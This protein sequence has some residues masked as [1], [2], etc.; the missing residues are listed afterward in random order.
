MVLIC[1]NA[2]P[3][4][5]IGNCRGQFSL[6]TFRLT[7]K[8][9]EINGVDFNSLD[10]FYSCLEKYLIEGDCP[11]GHNLD[12]F[13]EVVF[14]N[15]NYTG[16]KDNDVKKFVWHNYEK[17]KSDLNSKYKNGQPIIEIIEE[18][19]SRNPSMLFDKK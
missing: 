9:I 19:F 17:S 13:D 3:Q 4:T 8:T 11:W 7:M 16:I 10:S 14:C 12:S 18:I 5:V 15:F 6:S 2:K 1:H